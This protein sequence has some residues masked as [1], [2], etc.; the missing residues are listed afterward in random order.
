MQTKHQKGVK[1]TKT[2][3]AMKKLKELI[4]D[5]PRWAQWTITVIVLTGVAIIT[6]FSS[7]CSTTHKVVQSSSSEIISKGDSTITKTTIT[8]EQKGNAKGNKE[9]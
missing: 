5:L 3:K 8:Y 4:S 2:S 7:G 6:M 1:K 9:K